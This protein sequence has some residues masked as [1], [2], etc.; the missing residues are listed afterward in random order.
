MNDLFEFWD[1][2]AVVNLANKKPAHVCERL[3]PI[4]ENGKKAKAS[5]NLKE[6]YIFFKRWLSIVDWLQKQRHPLDK[7]LVKKN[8][9]NEQVRSI[10][11]IYPRTSVFVFGS[12]EDRRATALLHMEYVHKFVLLKYTRSDN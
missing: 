8:F 6:A 5:R 4:C 10:L 11:S 9:S 2:S 12:I 1:A 3:N 7:E